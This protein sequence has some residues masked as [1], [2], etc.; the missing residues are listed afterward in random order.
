M[1]L[2]EMHG[3]RRALRAFLDEGRKAGDVLTDGWLHGHLGLRRP[4]SGTYE[5]FQAFRLKELGAVSEFRQQLLDKQQLALEHVEG[6]FVV[7]TASEQLRRA[8]EEG[9]RRMRSA[10]RWQ[11]SMLLNTDVATLSDAE[12]AL[13]AESLA[14]MSRLKSI[15]R[16]KPALP[17]PMK[18]IAK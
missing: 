11:A 7:L 17:A 15:V 14:R 9:R 1:P 18:D 5:E 10:V 3:W 6:G 8:N 12:R 13:H 16:E 4:A 2:E